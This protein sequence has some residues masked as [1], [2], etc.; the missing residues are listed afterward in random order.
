MIPWKEK[1]ESALQELKNRLISTPIMK[2]PDF[3]KGFI[4]Q[5]DASGIGVGAVL[6]Q[7][8]DTR[9]DHYFSQQECQAIKLGIEA[10]ST[11]LFGKPFLIQTHHRVL[12]WMD[13]FKHGNNR[14]M[15]W[16]LGLQPYQFKVVHMKGRENA[17]VDTLSRILFITV[18]MGYDK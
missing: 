17:N 14:L 8:D 16:S 2:N 18:T 6:S 5:T 12:Q 11:Y 1:E 10:F 13:K 7:S 15:Q 3:T 4:L 9:L